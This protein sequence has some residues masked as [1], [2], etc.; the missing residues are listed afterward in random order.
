FTTGLDLWLMGTADGKK[1]ELANGLPG[2]YDL[3]F[4]GPKQRLAAQLTS[5]QIRVWDGVTGARID[6]HTGRDHHFLAAN[7]GRN[8]ATDHG[9]TVRLVDFNSGNDLHHFAGHRLTPLVRFALSSG[10]TLLS[11]DYEHAYHW[12]A[13]SWKARESIILPIR[14]NKYFIYEGSNAPES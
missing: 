11:R 3:A 9:N 10:D 13:R 7:N 12:N 6:P 5:G 4:L 1:Q 8:G 14:A 2:V